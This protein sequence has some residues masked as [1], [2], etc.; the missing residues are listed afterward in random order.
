M[1][2]KDDSKY[3]E[4]QDI[5]DTKSSKIELADEAVDGLVDEWES[6]T[7]DTE[8]IEVLQVENLADSNTHLVNTGSIRDIESLERSFEV[9][10]RSK[11]LEV[12]YFIT[13]F[14]AV[15][16]AIWTVLGLID[17]FT[18]GNTWLLIT[19]VGP[20]TLFGVIVHYFFK[21]P[22]EGGRYPQQ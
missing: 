7:I 13:F 12:R 16:F 8:E 1:L 17:L 20:A 6:I 5:A 19:D 9:L 21:S 11:E 15:L 22:N 14:M 18:T 3:F 2:D 4:I 10:R